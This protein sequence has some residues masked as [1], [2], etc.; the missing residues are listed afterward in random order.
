MHSYK[1]WKLV[2]L[3]QVRVAPRGLQSLIFIGIHA[4]Y[5]YSCLPPEPWY[6]VA[7]SWET[8]NYLYCFPNYSINKWSN[9]RVSP[10]WQEITFD[11]NASK[12]VPPFYTICSDWLSSLQNIFYLVFIHWQKRLS[13]YFLV[14][15]ILLL[16]KTMAKIIIQWKKLEARQGYLTCINLSIKTAKP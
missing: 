13:S 2:V 1:V 12:L 16:V 11:W 10:Y 4:K 8:G 15:I 14:T 5:V 7:F 9:V 3:L 6:F